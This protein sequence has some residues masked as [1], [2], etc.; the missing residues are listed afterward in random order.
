MEKYNYADSF[1][2]QWN[3]HSQTQLDSHSGM[4]ISKDRFNRET[5]WSRDL[6]GDLI[7]EVGCGSGRFTK[8]ALDTG[9]T[10]VSIDYSSAIEENFNNNGSNN[11]LLV[12][13]ADLYEMPFRFNYFDKVFCFGVLQHTPDP[14]KSFQMLV[15]HL[16]SSGQIATD[17]YFKSFRRIFHIKFWVRPFVK[18]MEREQLYSLTRN[19][20]DTV[21]PI[22]RLL[23]VTK[24]GQIIAS[25]FVADRSNLIKGSTKSVGKIICSFPNAYS[26]FRI[27]SEHVFRKIWI[28]KNNLL[29]ISYADYRR[30]LFREK[31]IRK[32][33]E[34]I[35]S[36]D[37]Y[38]ARYFGV[39]LIPQPFDTLFSSLDSNIVQ[40]FENKPDRVGNIF[41][42]EFLVSFQKPIE[43]KTVN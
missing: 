4:T 5:K 38:P 39:K 27:W 23:A 41:A 10:V 29:K 35:S 40:Y 32:I 8:I 34:N 28:L 3:L 15:D 11:R 17:V 12:V 42:Q 18:D 16:K 7:L 26:P 22:A 14:E 36:V 9:A 1:G 24:L 21:W 37:Y 13:Q 25:R 31:S 6:S 30:T 43:R 2:L 33:F 19:Y 20:V